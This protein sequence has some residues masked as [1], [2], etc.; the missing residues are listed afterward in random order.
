MSFEP[1]SLSPRDAA[2][3]LAVSRRTVSRLIRSRK[4]VARKLGERTLVDYESIKTL[5]ASLPVKADHAPLVFG[6][7]AHIVPRTRGRH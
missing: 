1:L 4:L 6:R 5:Y 7:R 2:T 3:M